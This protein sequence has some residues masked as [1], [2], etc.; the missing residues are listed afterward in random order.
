MKSPLPYFE[1]NGN[2]L[3]LAACFGAVAVYRVI[4]GPH[5]RVIR[6]PITGIAADARARRAERRSKY[7]NA[8][9]DRASPP[10]PAGCGARYRRRAQPQTEP[11]CPMKTLE[12]EFQPGGFVYRQI[13]RDGDLAVYEQSKGR[14]VQSYEVVRIQRRE[15][16]T[17][18]DG[19]IRIASATLGMK[20]GV[21]TPGNAPSDPRATSGRAATS[22]GVRRG[23][24]ACARALWCGAR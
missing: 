13:A 3:A 2:Y 4:G 20:V 12:T 6:I 15:A 10:E 16:E 9:A 18:A 14:A 8:R 24:R 17:S 19:S 5:R 1:R 11:E 21:S 22:C 23:G 7:S